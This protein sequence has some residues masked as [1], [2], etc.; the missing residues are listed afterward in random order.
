MRT[1]A[2]PRE[3]L[4]ANCAYWDPGRSPGRGVCRR[5]APTP[6]D[7][8]PYVGQWPLTWGDE[9]CGQHQLRAPQKE[10]D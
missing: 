4:C 2:Q 7:H 8:H 10:G 9:W 1:P 6:V 5:S 3:R